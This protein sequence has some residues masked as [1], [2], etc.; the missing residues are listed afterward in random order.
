LTEFKDKHNC[1]INNESNMGPDAGASRL[2]G[3]TRAVLAMLCLFNWAELL[4]PAKTPSFRSAK[5]NKN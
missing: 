4:L 3:L 2:C 1:D 5:Y